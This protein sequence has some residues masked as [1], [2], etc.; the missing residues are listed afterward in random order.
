MRHAGGWVAS[1]ALAALCAAVPARGFAPTGACC[2]PAGACQDILQFTCEGQGGE[3]LGGGTM[4][5]TVDCSTPTTAPLLS[6]FGL[7]AVVGA[8]AGL[9]SYR[10]LYQ[11]RNR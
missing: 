6:F 5:A 8:L 7:V 2:L 11:R 9:G 10:L 4:C 3:F 1:V